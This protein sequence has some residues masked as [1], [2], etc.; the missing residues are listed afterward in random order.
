M[1]PGGPRPNDRPSA[2]PSDDPFGFG[3]N[4]NYVGAALGALVPQALASRMVTVTIETERTTYNVGEP[5]RFT[6][7]IRNRLPVPVA[8]ETTRN[9]LWG[10]TVDGELEASDEPRR[11]TER[12]NA[13]SLRG[14]ERKRITREWN[15]RFRRTR[16][17]RTRWVRA[18]PGEHELGVF[19]TTRRRPSDSV[20]IE[21][22]E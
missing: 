17:G 5:V 7:T 21:L 22:R 14:N 9:R 20:T 15:G 2:N 13:I 10:W 12:A 1:D 3:E 8:V 6:V 18:T 11:R 19:L 4:R 16:E